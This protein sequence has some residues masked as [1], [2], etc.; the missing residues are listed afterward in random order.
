MCLNH[1][2]IIPHP[3]SMENLSSMKTVSGVEIVT[4]RG[5]KIYK[6]FSIYLG[7]KH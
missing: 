1:T 5:R 4:D 2:E 6:S 7:M 3:W